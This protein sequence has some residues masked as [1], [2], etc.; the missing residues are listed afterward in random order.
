MILSGV[1]H[2]KRIVNNPFLFGV[3][4]LIG[5]LF[6]M[7]LATSLS[8]NAPPALQGPVHS[9]LEVL[10]VI[11]YALAV[12]KILGPGFRLG[13]C[14]ARLGTG[15]RLLLV[16]LP[17]A[18]VNLREFVL[19]AMTAPPAVTGA[20]VPAALFPALLMGIRPGI[21][22][23]LIFRGLLMGGFLH[24]AAG[25]PWRIRGAAVF[26]S[27]IF[28]LMHLNNLGHGQALSVTLVQVMYAFSIGMLFAAVYARTRS[29]LP[30]IFLH[31][32][33]DTIVA[34]KQALFLLPDRQ[35][36]SPGELLLYVLLSLLW[37]GSGVYLL[38]DS[39][40]PAM[41]AL[42]DSAAPVDPR[43]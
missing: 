30:A 40:Q 8:L 27:V 43:G 19:A 25:K 28:A 6:F 10:L 21:T 4:T 9:V 41:H 16:F 1:M 42:W 15:F 24:L 17:A 33:V 36:V 37:L 32:L 26:S 3:L 38:R 11:V 23:E 13:I 39:R 20:A 2:M 34:L 22:E 31:A 7:G 35:T 14:T 29:L 5:A 12:K 18:V